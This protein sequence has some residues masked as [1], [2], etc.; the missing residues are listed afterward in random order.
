MATLSIIV[1]DALVPRIRAAFLKQVI[2]DGAVTYVQMT[3]AE[4]QEEIKINYVKPR[5][6]Q[7][8]ANAAAQAV[9]QSGGQEVW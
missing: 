8:E 1:A 3:I 2:V 5:V 4:I 7:S 6:V 9:N